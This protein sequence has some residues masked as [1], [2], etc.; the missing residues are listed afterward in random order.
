MALTWDQV[1]AWRMAQHKLTERAERDEM[2][3]VVRR[4]DGVHA[5]L[6]SAA[7]LALGARINALRPDDVQAALWNERSLVKSW[8]M[9]G[10]LHLVAAEDFPL[11]IGALSSLRHFRRPSWLKHHGVSL[12]ELESIIE[13]VRVTLGGSGMTRK[14]LV[15]AIVEETQEP[16]LAELL[17]S[18]WGALLK[19]AAYQGYL[20]YGPSA[21]QK[22]TFASPQKWLGPWRP[23]EPEEALKEM[24]RRFLNAYGP[25][26]PE[27][28][29]RWLGLPPSKA[30]GVF[31]S[32]GDEIEEVDLEGW[33]SWALASTVEQM[34]SLDRS[35]TVR[36]LP[37][38]DPYVVAAYRHSAYLVA[39]ENKGRVYR[40]Q[41]WIYPVVLVDGRFAGV[42]ESEEKRSRLHIS[43]ELFAEAGKRVKTGIESEAARLGR[44][45]GREVTLEFK[46][47][48]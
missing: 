11:I 3:S 33:L 16:Q 43:V 18:G 40:P 26:A 27:E 9:R 28:F 12:E 34:K 23:L 19:P 48:R 8:F 29:G 37:Y 42:W 1:T 24:A 38:F 36:L 4:I 5:Q 13:A 7:E 30:K 45:S 46:P 15:E 2:I 39:E 20:C 41:G 47:D 17:R 25:A 10:T 22:V 32:L 21:G 14:Q 6:M 35:P 31:R 44:C